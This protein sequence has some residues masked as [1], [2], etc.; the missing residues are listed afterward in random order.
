M[1][2][3]V[4]LAASDEVLSGPSTIQELREQGFETVAIPFTN[5]LLPHR[6][7]L[8]AARLFSLIRA[9]RFRLVHTYTAKA[10]VIGRLAARAARVPVVAHT[11]FSWPQLDMPGRA[12]LFGPLERMAARSCDHIFC[13]SRLGYRQAMQLGLRPR[14]GV[15]CPG[16]GLDLRGAAR[17]T[18]RQAARRRVGLPL[19]GLLVGAAGRLVPHKRLD[20]FLQ[21]CRIVADRLPAAQFAVVGDGPLR[22]DL[23]QLARGL[24]LSE[25]VIFLPYLGSPELVGQ[26]FRA[27]DVFVLPTERE[28]FGM[29]FAEAMAQETAV[30]GPRMAPIDEIVVDGDSGVLVDPS[31]V[32]AYADA[33]LRVLTDET[34]RQALAVAGRRRIWDHFDQER[35]FGQLERSYRALLDGAPVP[36]LDSP[37]DRSSSVPAIGGS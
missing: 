27:L 16:I 32:G 26:Y 4:T 5:R 31:N 15:S 19:D 3:Q 17:L 21:M 30:V 20:L 35:V 33:T 14:H 10:G 28:G 37:G 22:A 25:R 11:A 34:W 9:R 13:I 23:E 1:G 18:S 24:G 2:F 7:M 8:A 12:W 36:L 29:V 6:D